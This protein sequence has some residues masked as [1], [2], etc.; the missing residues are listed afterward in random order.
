MRILIADDNADSAATLRMLLEAEGRQ[1]AQ[2][3]MA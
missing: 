3:E 2:L 1:S